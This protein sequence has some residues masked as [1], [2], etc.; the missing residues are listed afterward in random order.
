M[1]L[2]KLPKHEL[3]L[4]IAVL[5][6]LAEFLIFVGRTDSSCDCAIY[7]LLMTQQIGNE[8]TK[9]NQYTRLGLF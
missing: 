2:G 7:F 5:F 6:V 1:W 4:L 9:T 3:Q 8:A